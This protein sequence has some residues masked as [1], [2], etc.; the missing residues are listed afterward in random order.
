ML[1]E[2]DLL[3]VAYTGLAGSAGMLVLSMAISAFNI[4]LK[5]FR[6]GQWIAGLF[7]VLAMYATCFYRGLDA[8]VVCWRETKKELKEEELEC[9]K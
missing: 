9:E 6:P 8:F 1:K 3:S 7:Q 2:L 4:N 5:W